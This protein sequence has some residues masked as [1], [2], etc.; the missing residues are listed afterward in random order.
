[1]FIKDLQDLHIY[2]ICLNILYIFIEIFYKYF[3]ALRFNK[4]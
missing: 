2:K 1:M 3:C 4:S